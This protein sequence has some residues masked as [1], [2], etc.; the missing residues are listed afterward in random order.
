LATEAEAEIL[1]CCGSRAWAHEM[2]R[3][4]PLSSKVELLSAAD[5]I[6]DRLSKEDWGEAFRSHW[7][8]GKSRAGQPSGVENVTE[9][10]ATWSAKEQ[11]AVAAADDALKI[12]LAEANLE[13]EK[14]FERTF[15]VCATGKSASEI[16]ALARQR[17]QNDE[18]TELRE[19]AEQQRQIT[20]IRLKKW[21]T[22]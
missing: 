16:L 19:A 3:R 4:R 5:E 11:G 6:W 12:A 7:R 15:I 17:L 10:S 1:P 18:E 2:A 14:R 9:R 8:I 22:E 20:Q 21:L 13:Y